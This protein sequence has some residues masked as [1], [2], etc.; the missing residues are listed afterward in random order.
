MTYI[1]CVERVGQEVTLKFATEPIGVVWA[2]AKH[3]VVA[4][5]EETGAL[6]PELFAPNIQAYIQLQNIGVAVP[7]TARHEEW[8]V[9]YAVFMLN[10]HLHYP[11]VLFAY[12]DVLWMHPLYRRAEL[13]KA[14][15]AH[16]ESDLAA[17]GARY[18]LR[19]AKPHRD[20][21]AFLISQG[22]QRHEVSY[23]K[24]LKHGG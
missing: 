10:T 1:S 20:Y 13:V 21:G 15:I 4:N 7:Y 22:Y 19:H 23:L 9:G 5:H 24:E 11:G 2:E 8:L 3:L 18:V 17:R 16:Q 12:Q 14:F 6:P